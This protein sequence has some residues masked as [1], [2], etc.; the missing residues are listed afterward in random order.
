VKKEVAALCLIMIFLAVFVPFASSN[1]DGLEKVVIT[2]G[3]QE[4]QSSWSGLMAD[5]SLTAVDNSYVSTIL[6][7]I[8]GMFTVLL[9]AFLLGR[10]IEPK[11]TSISEDK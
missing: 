8:L 4:H 2:Y 10:A 5:Y 7:G 1:P 3:A 11:K 9:A 6:A